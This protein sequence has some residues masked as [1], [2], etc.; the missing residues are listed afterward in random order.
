MKKIFI[1]L[2][3]VIIIMIFN[4]CS[5]E[6]LVGVNTNRFSEGGLRFQIQKSSIPSEVQQ[7]VADLSRS[8]Y[9]TLSTSI[10]VLNDSLNELSFNNVPI[11]KWHLVI[12]AE[13]SDGKIIYS[14]ATDVTVLEDQTIDVYL[15]LTSV[16]SGAGNI[17]IFVN[18]NQSGTKWVDFQN[19]PILSVKDIPYYTYA[20]DQAQVMFDNGK[21][22]VWFE[23]VYNSGHQEILVMPNRMMA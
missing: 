22:K 6:N 15:T 23:N 21:Y 19:N 3:S 20:V 14:G 2:V 16:G 9:D 18:W 10:N 8:N 4:D 7:I 1:L 5:N 17:N 12:D 13:N 11:G